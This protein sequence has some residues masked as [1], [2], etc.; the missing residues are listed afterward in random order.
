MIKKL[1]LPLILLFLFITASQISADEYYERVILVFKPNISKTQKYNLIN[2]NK[3]IWGK[4]LNLINAHAVKMPKSIQKLLLKN[5]KILRIDPDVEVYASDEISDKVNNLERVNAKSICDWFP[6]WPGCLPK[7]SPTPTPKASPQ[8]SP[9]PTLVPS[10]TINPSIN[11]SPL[12]SPS[13]SPA[14]SVVPSVSPVTSP[15]QSPTA[16]TIPW[17]ITKINAPSAWEFSSGENIK[18][19]VIDSGIDRDHPDLVNNISGCV[20]FINLNLT[21]EDDNGH[22]THVSGIIAAENNNLGIVGV[23]PGAKIYALKALNFR[24]SGYLSD[25]IEALD[26]SIANNMQIVNMSLGTTS[27]IQSLKDAIVRVKNAGIIQV[28]AAGNSGPRTN[29]VNYPAKY[30]EVIAVSATDIND[31]VPSWSSRGVEVDLGAPGVNV[32]S[33]YLNN[34]YTNMSGTSMATPYVAGLAAIRLANHPGESALS[35]EQILKNN[36]DFIN[37]DKTLIGSG[38]VNAYKVVMAN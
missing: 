6:K 29:S 13:S 23:A 22:G 19:A 25:I 32:N 11:P 16:Q 3:M 38:R 18:V 5:P 35:V 36:T 24:G 9:S 37:L 1:C 30:P 15:S 8:I 31:S 4:D 20:N 7:T 17:G 28:A 26:W 10:P 2:Q 33:T 21:C 14:P 34:N 12:T 27:N